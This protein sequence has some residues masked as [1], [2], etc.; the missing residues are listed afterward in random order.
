MSKQKEEKPITLT[1]EQL[2]RIITTAVIKAM[3]Q[4]KAEEELPINDKN[5]LA[6]APAFFS[7]LGILTSWLLVIFIIVTL[8]AAG[9]CFLI[10][11]QNG[12][13]VYGLVLGLAFVFIAVLSGVAIYEIDKTK[14]IEVLNT[15]FN[16]IMA[17][18]ALIV[19]V[20]SAVYAYKAIPEN[21]VSSSSIAAVESVIDRGE[22]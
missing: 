15:V 7:L 10:A 17:V 2:E 5:E 14:K 4:S 1:E 16:A 20:V 22:E 6:E 13:N 21:D 18:A 11:F 8:V 9:A 3:R 12:F 19:A